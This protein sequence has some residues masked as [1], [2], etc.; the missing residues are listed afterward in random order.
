MNHTMETYGKVE[1]RT[2]SSVDI[3]TTLQNKLKPDSILGFL[4]TSRLDLGP[5][6]LPYSMGIWWSF[7]VVRR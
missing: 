7:P 5:N 4:K 2:Q 3:V 1:V 6:H